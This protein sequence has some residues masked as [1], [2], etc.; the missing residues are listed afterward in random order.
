[1]DEKD[2][3]IAEL[4]A[5]LEI[6][7]GQLTNAMDAFISAQARLVVLQRQPPGQ[8]PGKP[9]KTTERGKAAPSSRPSSPSS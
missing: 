4:T 7:R 8:M 2:Q 5:R 1:M 9:R 6:Y 3:Q